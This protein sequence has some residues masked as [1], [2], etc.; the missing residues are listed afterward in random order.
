MAFTR[1]KDNL[2]Q[3]YLVDWER[4]SNIVGAHAYLRAFTQNAKS[5]K[6]SNLL[7]SVKTVEFNHAAVR[8]AKQ[9]FINSTVP[10]VVQTIQKDYRQGQGL[11]VTLRNQTVGYRKKRDE[12]FATAEASAKSFDWWAEK[13]VGAAQLARD[14]GFAAIAVVAVPVGG[15]WVLGATLF[16]AS[17]A[18]IGKY[19]DTGNVGSALVSGASSLIMAGWGSVAGAAKATGAAKGV[20]IGMGCVMDSTFEMMGAVAEGKSGSDVAKAG[21]MKLVTGGL[22]A[23]MDAS[24][25]A[26]KVDDVW[27]ELTHLKASVGWRDAAMKVSME[28]AKKGTDKLGG[29]VL[30][31]V[32]A[33]NQAVAQANG[34]L[35]RQEVLKAG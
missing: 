26:G 23:G 7:G 30:D 33:A 28:A 2:G 3:S 24:K 15:S 32:A 35:V 22:G 29:A 1:G 18:A 12:L 4:V 8:K 20:L 6:E 11:L 14:T 10:L 27:E 17:G 19:Q 21:V 16:S 13:A 25:V 31:Q 5:G 34:S 9:A